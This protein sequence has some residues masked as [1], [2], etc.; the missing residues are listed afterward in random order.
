MRI[1]WGQAEP[2][3]NAPLP[4]ED[5]VDESAPTGG[6]PRGNFDAVRQTEALHVAYLCSHTIDSAASL[7][8]GSHREMSSLATT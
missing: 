5:I 1:C 2:V 7:Q 6:K 8:E 4:D 3:H